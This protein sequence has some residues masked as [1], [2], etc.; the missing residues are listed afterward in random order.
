MKTK[1]ILLLF[2]VSLSLCCRLDAQVTIGLKEEPAKGALLQL[3]NLPQDENGVNANKGLGMPLVPLVSNSSLQPCI[4]DNTMAQDENVKL[5]HI[6][7][8]VYNTGDEITTSVEDQLCKG[9]HVWNGSKWKPFIPYPQAANE[10]AIIQCQPGPDFTLSCTDT[11]VYGTYNKG[12]TLGDPNYIS[13][14]MIAPEASVGKKYVIKAYSPDRSDIS[15]I[16]SGTILRTEDV[17][18]LKGSGVVS[19]IKDTYFTIITNSSTNTTC[20]ALV[21]GTIPLLN[22]VGVGSD[23]YNPAS[24]NSLSRS[25]ILMS[26]TA[27]FG[28]NENAVVRSAGFNFTFHNAITEAK[29]L[30]IFSSKPDIIIRT[31]N[32]PLTNTTAVKTALLN[33]LN[34]GGVFLEFND[35]NGTSSTAVQALYGSTAS[36]EG[37]AGVSGNLYTILNVNDELVNGVWGNLQGK[38]WA[39]DASV[40]QGVSNVDESKITIYSRGTYSSKT[41]ITAFRDKSLH[42]FYLGDGGFMSGASTTGTLCCYPF[43]LDANNMPK[44]D[45]TAWGTRSNSVFFANIIT[46]A[47]KQAATDGINTR[48]K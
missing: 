45:V 31:Y 44:D 4:E 18:K 32:L 6:G 24:K 42:Y 39:E 25:Y 11:K 17:I 38:T 34:A 48:G 10:F 15:F 23:Y 36:S 43:Q 5:A 20:S 35:N 7:L 40:T 14:K 21:Q 33:Y 29:W 19:T 27:A 47:M 3:K 13:V 41:F 46:W 28:N 12:A 30:A 16:A 8:T 9:M 26:N 1:A 37:Y 22:I 2:L